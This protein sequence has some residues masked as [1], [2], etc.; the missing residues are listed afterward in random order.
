[1]QKTVRIQPVDQQDEARRKEL[2][3]T[4]PAQRMMMLFALVDQ[5]AKH[6]RLARIARI[7]NV[8]VR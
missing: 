4:T 1:M 8:S 5:T 6:P 7:R 2:A 3:T